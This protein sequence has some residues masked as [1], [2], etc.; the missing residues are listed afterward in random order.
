MPGVALGVMSDVGWG[1]RYGPSNFMR[2]WTKRD[3]W[4]VSVFTLIPNINRNQ[5]IGLN[6]LVAV[7][8]RSGE[9]KWS[10]ETRIVH[11]F[12]SLLCVLDWRFGLNRSEEFHLLPDWITGEQFFFLRRGWLQSIISLRSNILPLTLRSLLLTS[13]AVVRSQIALWISLGCGALPHPRNEVPRESI[14]SHTN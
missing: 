1:R 12:F 10:I 4:L 6:R 3:Y 9:G 11:P 13:L 5:R 7:V 8:F 2:N 14:V